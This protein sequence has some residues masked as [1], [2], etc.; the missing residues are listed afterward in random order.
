MALKLLSRSRTKG[1]LND[2]HSPLA[3]RAALVGFVG[4]MLEY[5]DFVLYGA[6][7]ALIFPKVFFVNLDPTTATLLSLSAS[8]LA[9]SR[10]PS[11]QSSLAI[12]ATD[13]A[14]KPF[15]CLPC[16]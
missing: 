15:C 16:V 2:Q 10:V 14:A 8:G 3:G 1:G 12:M 6:A 4:T 5:Y 13:S 7:A 11:G 9:L